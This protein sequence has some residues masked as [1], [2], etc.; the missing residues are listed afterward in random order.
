[1]RSNHSLSFFFS[2]L[3]MDIKQL[4]R[5]LAQ[6]PPRPS[7]AFPTWRLSAARSRV[8]KTPVAQRG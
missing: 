3:L 6:D 7:S 4:G 2:A 5:A 8:A 1:L